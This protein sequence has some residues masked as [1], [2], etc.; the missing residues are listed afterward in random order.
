MKAKGGGRGGIL[1]SMALIAPN[2][3]GQ[4]QKH[5][6][7]SK[8]ALKTRFHAGKKARTHLVKELLKLPLLD[9]VG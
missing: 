1:M 9:V 3:I 7:V 4:M 8:H 2:C 5:T 6:Y